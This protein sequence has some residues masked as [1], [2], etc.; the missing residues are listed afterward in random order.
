LLIKGLLPRG[1]DTDPPLARAQSD[2]Y[3]LPLDRTF[4]IGRGR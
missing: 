4:A 2:S 3:D 1:L